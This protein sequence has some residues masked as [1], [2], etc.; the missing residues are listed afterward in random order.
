MHIRAAASAGALSMPLHCTLKMVEAGVSQHRLIVIF[1]HNVTSEKYLDPHRLF[2]K[3]K[4]KE[5]CHLSQVRVIYCI[6]ARLFFSLSV[7]T[8]CGFVFTAL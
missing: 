1:H 7:T 4:G 3:N 8:H 5:S 6:Y 2:C